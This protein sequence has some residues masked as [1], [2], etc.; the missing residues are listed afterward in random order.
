MMNVKK[1]WEARNQ[2]LEGIKNKIFKSDAVEAI[3][4]E[5]NKICE[6]CE[7]YDPNGHHCLIPG[8]QPCCGACGC[9]LGLKQ[10]SLSSACD[11]GYWEPVLT[12][13]EDLDHEVLNTDEDEH[14]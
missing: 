2:I 13:E 11:E 12:E 4:A 1:V 10:R 3:A 5:R 7:F 6:K 8:T 14:S 9:S